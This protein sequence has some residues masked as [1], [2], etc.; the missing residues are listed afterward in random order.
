M[1]V[2]IGVYISTKVSSLLVVKYT[3]SSVYLH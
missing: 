2:I 1:I 3:L